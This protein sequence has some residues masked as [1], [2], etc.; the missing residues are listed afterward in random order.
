MSLWNNMNLDSLSFALAEISYSVANLNKKNFRS[1]VAE[2][3]HVRD[4]FLQSSVFFSRIFG[5]ETQAEFYK[6]QKA[7]IFTNLKPLYNDLPL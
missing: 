2:I 3:N 5:L 1:S 4:S 6:C 7:A